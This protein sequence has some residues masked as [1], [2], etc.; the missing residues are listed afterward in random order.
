[1]EN[2][3]LSSRAGYALQVPIALM[4]ALN[5]LGPPI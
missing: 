3:G 4:V 1:M 2:G 5:A